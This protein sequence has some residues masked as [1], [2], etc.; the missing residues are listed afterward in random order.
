[1]PE[2]D[3]PL[4]LYEDNQACYYMAKNGKWTNATKHVATMYFAVRDDIIDERI[5]LL[6]VDSRDNLAGIFTKPLTQKN[7]ER[8]REAIGVRD[9][10]V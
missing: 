5:D 7:F 3:L 6:P 8:F 10:S 4:P 9:A 1:M 2:G